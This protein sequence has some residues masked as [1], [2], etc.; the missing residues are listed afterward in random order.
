MKFLKVFFMELSSQYFFA[1]NGLGVVFRRCRKYHLL[2][3]QADKRNSRAINGLRENLEIG[4]NNSYGVFTISS[5]GRSF[6]PETS[7]YK[8]F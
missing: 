8:R 2:S 3:L 1:K 4:E 6:G 5:V 7:N